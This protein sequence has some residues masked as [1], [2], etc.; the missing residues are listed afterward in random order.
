MPSVGALHPPCHPSIAHISAV[1]FTG[2]AQHPPK[3]VKFDFYYMHCL[4]SSIFF[5]SFLAA[6]F[7][8]K[9][10][11]AR[12]LA[13][14]GRND[15]GLYASRRSASPLLDEISNYRPVKPKESDW[16]SVIKRVVLHE[17]DGHA[18]KLVR[19]LK[20]GEEISKPY[21]GNPK[22]KI[23]GQ[24][25]ENLGNMGMSH[26]FPRVCNGDRE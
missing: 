4:N 7:I 14:K 5:S 6:P 21:E 16:D 15:L 13:W 1:Y 19:A 9:G 3:Q 26:V 8:S 23:Q 2:G 22:F 25:W 18:S 12:L 11:K 24:M 20:H 17:D 10:N